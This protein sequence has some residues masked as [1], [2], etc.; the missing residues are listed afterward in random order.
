MRTEPACRILD[1]LFGVAVFM[2]DVEFGAALFDKVFLAWR[3]DTDDEHAHPAGCDLDGDVAKLPS[4]CV[5][6]VV[7]KK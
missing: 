2:I 5:S 7:R 3:I 1:I 4:K 6:D